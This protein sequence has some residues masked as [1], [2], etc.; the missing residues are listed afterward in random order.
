M[1]ED[2]NKCK[3]EFF[4]DLN[5]RKK[6]DWHRGIFANEVAFY[7]MLGNCSSIPTSRLLYCRRCERANESTNSIS[8]DIVGRGLFLFEMKPDSIEDQLWENLNQAQQ[9]K[10][11]CSF[12]FAG[13]VFANHVCSDL[14]FLTPPKSGQRFSSSPFPILWRLSG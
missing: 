11:L 9:V 5:C 3:F 8:K 4:H 6:W 14:S 10:R 7:S 1:N 12:C 2:P 13:S